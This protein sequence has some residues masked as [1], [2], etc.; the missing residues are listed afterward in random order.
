MIMST[1]THYSGALEVYSDTL[2]TR[3]LGKLFANVQ[4]VWG[5]LGEGLA[6]SRRYQ[7]LTS[8]GMPHEQAA[9]KVFFEHFDEQ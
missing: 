1:T 2:G 5:A 3:R 6:A 4:T 7:E 8:R 9:S